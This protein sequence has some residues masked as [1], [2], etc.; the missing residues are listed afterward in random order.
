MSDIKDASLW[1]GRDSFD[2]RGHDS[3][4]PDGKSVSLT[5]WFRVCSSCDEFPIA[6]I[7]QWTRQPWPRHPLLLDETG[8]VEIKSCTFWMQVRSLL[9]L[10]SDTGLI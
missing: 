5:Q 1:A 10:S 2:S 4:T 8:E 6:W 9:D 3:S 7:M